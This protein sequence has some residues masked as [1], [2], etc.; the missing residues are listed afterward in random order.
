M[1]HPCASCGIL[2]CRILKFSR[3]FRINPACHPRQLRNLCDVVARFTNIIA[4]GTA[5]EQDMVDLKLAASA[6][7][8]K[9]SGHPLIVGLALQC[10]RKLCK[11]EKGHA[12]MRGRREQCTPHERE[13]IRDAG[14][15]LC[16]ATGNSRLAMEFG[17]SQGSG[18][19]NMQ[20]LKEKSLPT[21][22]LAVLWPDV[23][24]ENFLLADQKYVRPEGS[25]KSA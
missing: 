6:A 12:D 2:L 1:T 17:L 25:P 9:L 19:V 16:A 3:G 13:L 23:L 20:Q 22:A 15:Q 18:R 8:G 11:E 4:G 24:S 7:S 10:H 5:S 14:L 21:P